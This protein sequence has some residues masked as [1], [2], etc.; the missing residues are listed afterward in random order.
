MIK[1]GELDRYLLREWLRVFLFTALGFPV[2]VSVIELT[3][4]LSRYLSRDISPLDILI[5]YLIGVP[6]IIFLVLPSAVLF[7][8]VFSIGSSSRHSELTAMKA[9]GRSFHRTILPVVAISLATSVFGLALGEAAPPWSRRKAELLGETQGRSSVTRFNF[10]Y[11]ADDGWVYIIRSLDAAH[12]QMRDVILE[13]KGSGPEYPTLVIQAADGRYDDS[14][15]WRFASG[16][17]RVLAGLLHERAFAF[18]S[19]RSAT[20]VETPDELLAQ[21]KAPEE[22]RYAELGNYIEA[23][24][25]SGGDA[26]KLRVQ[27]ALKIAIPFTCLVIAIFGAPMAISSPRS[28]GAFGVAVSLAT[29]VIFLIL[30]QLSQAIGSGGIL[31]PTLAAWSPNILFGTI[32][33][34]LLHRAPT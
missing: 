28:G 21:P 17:Y 22:M 15:G 5:G 10:V 16:R 13:R 11:R 1:F 23:L 29:T 7:A 9:S 8:T 3:D 25:R 26:R 14:R 18:D 2:I 31:P 6:E 34:F 4:R 33:A 19:L 24:E 12:S 30:V 27:Q 20:L 32:G